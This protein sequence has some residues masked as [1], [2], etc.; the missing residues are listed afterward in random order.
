MSRRSAHKVNIDLSIIGKVQG[1]ENAAQVKA[2]TAEI[3]ELKTAQ[4]KEKRGEIP[5]PAAVSCSTISQSSL[6]LSP[7][8]NMKLTT[9]AN[10]AVYLHPL[11]RS[12]GANS[13][14][15]HAYNTCNLQEVTDIMTKYAFDGNE[16]VTAEL[17]ARV[18]LK[19]VMYNPTYYHYYN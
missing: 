1:D 9:G 14:G 3:K 4:V 11:R 7:A 15:S 10:A 2:L 12:Q 19:K 16:S 8:D 13:N 17:V 6:K 18:S 5:R